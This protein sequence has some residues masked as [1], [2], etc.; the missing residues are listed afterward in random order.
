MTNFKQLIEQAI[1]NLSN[2]YVK[3]EPNSNQRLFLGVAHMRG[4]ALPNELLLKAL[5]A[6]RRIQ[7]VVESGSG[8][9]EEALDI[10]H[11]RADEV[12]SEIRMALEGTVK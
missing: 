2:D 6:L 12:L 9:E 11:K 8:T 10:I 4:A 3:D 7:F 1:D 5:E